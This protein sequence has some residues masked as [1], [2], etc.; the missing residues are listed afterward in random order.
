[1]GRRRRATAKLALVP[2]LCL[3]AGCASTVQ[4]SGSDLAQSGLGLDGTGVSLGTA[5]PGTAGGAVA[6]S[7]SGSAVGGA[8]GATGG[9]VTGGAGAATSSGGGQSSGAVAGVSGG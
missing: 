9:A 7:S 1:M 6:G 4:P 8:G 5:A 2:A 3:P